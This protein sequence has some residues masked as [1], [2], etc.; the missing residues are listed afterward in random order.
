MSIGLGG[1]KMGRWGAMSL[2]KPAG[3]GLETR[4]MVVV[5]QIKKNRSVSRVN[6]IFYFKFV[7]YR[8]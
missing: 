7:G 5:S 6:P 3:G 4:P 8:I 2:A 1:S